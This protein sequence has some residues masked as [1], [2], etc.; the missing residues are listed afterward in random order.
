[1][2]I[3]A[4]DATILKVVGI[5]AI[6][7]LT[8]VRLLY[9]DVLGNE[10]SIISIR[11]KHQQV[12]ELTR[13]TQ[14][15][16]RELSESANRVTDLTE[17]L[18]P[19]RGKADTIREQIRGVDFSMDM[20]SV[21]IFIEQHANKTNLD[22][23]VEYD[24]IETFEGGRPARPEEGMPGERPDRVP[25]PEQ[26]PD[27]E[28]P[29]EGQNPDEPVSNES[30]TDDEETPPKLPT[31][32]EDTEEDIEDEELGQGSGTESENETLD[33][34]PEGEAPVEMK[35]PFEDLLRESVRL[36][37]Q[38]IPMIPGVSVTNI[39]V[40][41]NGTYAEIRAFL[42]EL[43]EIDFLESSE[44]DLSSDGNSLSG[45]ISLNVFHTDN[46]GGSY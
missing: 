17:Q 26:R 2:K 41:I 14:F 6:I 25:N 4:R 21:L 46:G 42:V 19:L 20:A 5:F 8:I 1:M 7:I 30:D 15:T 34:T 33:E 24:G 18:V 32:D 43:D 3:S 39:P 35:K 13:E 28:Q 29:E 37:S 45:I 38:D 22:L 12:Q 27:G 40:R 23:V 9:P 31:S 11:E 16:E 10:H 44:I 36:S